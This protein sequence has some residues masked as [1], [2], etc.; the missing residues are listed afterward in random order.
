[1]GKRLARIRFVGD[2]FFGRSNMSSIKESHIHDISSGAAPVAVVGNLEGPITSTGVKI[3]KNGPHLRNPPSRCQVLKE[4]GITHVSLANNH[5]CDFGVRGI[6]STEEVLGR[7]GIQFSGVYRDGGLNSHAMMIET[8]STKVSILCIGEEEFNSFEEF[9]IHRCNEKTTYRQITELL[10]SCDIVIVYIHGGLEYH[11]I[12]LPEIRDLYRY[13]IDIG[14]HAV[15]ASHPH[16]WG[17]REIYKRKPIY[18]SLGNYIFNKAMNNH[19][20]TD[21]MI[22]DIDIDTANKRIDSWH[23]QFLCE[24]HEI[25]GV[26]TADLSERT[27]L[28]DM[29]VQQVL[30]SDNYF[31]DYWKAAYIRELEAS[32]IRQLGFVFFPGQKYLVMILFWLLGTLLRPAILVR[33]NV[34]KSRSLRH[35]T[36]GAMSSWLDMKRT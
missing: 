36:L 18:Y 21:G 7:L 33:A 9:G 3:A 25:S 12:P 31:S 13:Y 8:G 15:I 11:R 14:A 24:S 20:N 16:V 34:L 5:I 4:L 22:L 35:L 32:A 1:M 30:N 26:Y 17:G 29:K 6:E 27:F 28:D 10:D 23:H 19:R 2:I